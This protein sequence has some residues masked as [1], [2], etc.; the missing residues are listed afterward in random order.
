MMR[1]I[2]IGTIISR[3][4]RLDL[5]EPADYAMAESCLLV[6]AWEAEVSRLAGRADVS[7]RGTHEMLRNEHL[8][9]V[10][11][12]L[13]RHWRLPAYGW[14]RFDYSSA[15]RPPEAAQAMPEVS[16][17]SRHLR[18]QEEMRPEAKLR[19]LRALSVHVLCNTKQVRAMA[20]CFPAGKHKQD[21]FCLVHTRVVDRQHL[22][23]PRLLHSS[24][25]GPEDR[26][27]LLR[28]VG[29]LHLLNPLTPEGLV[30]TSR[31]LV[32]DER[33]V[34]EFLLGLSAKERGGKVVHE[35]PG[36]ALPNMASWVK[37]GVPCQDMTLQVSY[38]CEAASLYW[39]QTL[40]ERYS[41]WRTPPSELAAKPRGEK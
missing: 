34:L 14:L 20:M 11:V 40:A 21:F 19:A 31:C 24:A 12:Q 38:A 29:H 17:V 18:L 32:H 10:A 23:G 3:H 15:W 6:S 22:L 27:E 37:T 33:R 2:I 4:Y 26:E 35:K 30:F 28:R 25:F 36:K 41:V 39:R 8:D 16:E 13:T 9:D 1:M 7:Q 5:A